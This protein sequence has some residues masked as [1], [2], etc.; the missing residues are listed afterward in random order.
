MQLVDSEATVTLC[1]HDK[2]NGLALSIVINNQK[3][4]KLIIVHR[5][6]DIDTDQ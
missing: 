5:I 2:A 3:K 4:K 1:R 6:L